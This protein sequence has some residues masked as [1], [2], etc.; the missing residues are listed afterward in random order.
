MRD[1]DWL[2][3]NL[4]GE[5]PE[6][7]FANFISSNCF[8]QYISEPTRYDALL[9]LIFSDCCD[10]VHA[11][12]VV[13]PFSS[14]DHCSVHFNLLFHLARNL[15][16]NDVNM[17]G[18]LIFN[19][20]LANWD[21]IN[22][23]LSSI[24][25]SSILNRD[26]PI[27]TAWAAFYKIIHSIMTDYIPMRHTALTPTGGSAKRRYPLFIRKLRSAKLK[28]WKLLKSSPTNDVLKQ[29]YRIAALA[30]KKAANDWYIAHE[31]RVISNVNSSAFYR[32]IGSLLKS[33]HR[34]TVLINNAGEILSNTYD[35]ANEFNNYFA[36]VFTHDNGT[37]PPFPSRCN[38]DLSQ[39]FFDVLAVSSVIKN[40]K[41]STAC[42]F[43]NIPNVFL[44]KTVLQITAPLCCLF[45]RSLANNYLPEIW[46]AA[47]VIPIHKKGSTNSAA[48][49]RPIS[50][51]SS[52]SKVMERV[53][54]NQLT[55]FL[56]ARNLITSSQFGFQQRSSTGIQL[57]DSHCNWLLNQNSYTPT[58]VIYLDYAKAFDSVS[59]SK[60]IYKL[61]AYGINHDLLRWITNYLS[62][63][64]QAVSINNAIS[65]FLPVS[66]GVP[67][68]S[69][70]GPLLFT[71]YINDLPDQIPAPIRCHLFADDAKLSR[72]INTI[73]DCIHLQSA[74]IIIFQWSSAWQLFLSIPKCM[75]LHLGRSNPNFRYNLSDVQL[76]HQ[77][78]VKDLGVTVSS[79]LTYHKHIEII[80][81]AAIK[82]IHIISKCF[83]SRDISTL[84]QIFVSFIRPS[85]E[86]CSVIWNPW[87]HRE[88]TS[89]ERVQERFTALAYH[90]PA[91]PSYNQR[92]R[93]FALPTLKLRRDHIDLVMY[94]KILHDKTRIRS[95]SLFEL[96]AR[97]ARRSNC[98]AISKPI[99]RTSAFLHSFPVRAISNWNKLS[100]NVIMLPASSFART[101]ASLS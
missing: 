64:T 72:T 15:P 80:V 43:D 83:H 71:L 16:S 99:C 40:L 68:G 9:D 44:V 36:S 51:V 33:S 58:D 34:G 41:A 66:S 94:H 65:S 59:H 89:L 57:I 97:S 13:E 55:S 1:V 32:H 38:D 7:L 84:R 56:A 49:F 12:S 53:I 82:K 48:N 101:V 25:W 62:N 69:V 19:F 45:E 50:L 5:R 74:L 29:S 85:L 39:V 98:L 54:V 20:A 79:N 6:H 37:L 26:L 95:T 91:V 70:I 22:A 87:S 10:S 76:G 88:I 31:Q 8:N 77:Q 17:S 35:V 63:R 18:N 23:A 86:Y 21:A 93:D 61:R 47:K 3:P 24:N 11:V 75:V 28:A 60:L 67:Q 46:K 78:Y 92:L 100:D 2:Q 4:V 52:I 96:N 42:S 90:A 81:S 73:G 30:F 27:E 14:S